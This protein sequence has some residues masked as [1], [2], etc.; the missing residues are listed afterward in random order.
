[1]IRYPQ[2]F[3]ETESDIFRFL[4]EVKFHMYIY[5]FFEV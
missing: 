4:G 2:L 5:T 3:G 1:M